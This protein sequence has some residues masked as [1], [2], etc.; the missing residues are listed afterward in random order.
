MRIG[1]K[2]PLAYLQ[3]AGIRKE[4]GS[5]AAALGSH[6]LVVASKRTIAEM[7]EEISGYLAAAG[8][9]CSFHVFA[10][11]I[12]YAEIDNTVASI[13]KNGCDI[14]L[15]LGGGRVLDTARAAADI[16]KIPLIIMPTSASNDAPCSAVAIIHDEN[17]TVIER[18]EVS[19][20]PNLVLVDTEI[21]AK[22]PR[23]LLTS[24]MGDAL[25]TYFE[26]RACNKSSAMTHAGGV[27][28]I[29]ALTLSKLCYDMLLEYGVKALDALDRG[30][31]N[32]DLEQLI[33]AVIYL[34]GAGFENGGTAAS[35]SVN[36][37]FTAIPEGEK[38]LH[39]M[40]VG[41]GVLVQLELENADSD[42]QNEVRAF[43]SKVGLPITLGQ[44]GLP[45][46]SEKDLRTIA[47]YACR[48]P[49]MNNMPFVV[50]PEDVYVAINKVDAISH[51]FLK[52]QG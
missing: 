24:G 13:Q 52:N 17:G 47:E 3:E 19:R 26:S 16:V 39:G 25:A 37:G 4:L 11:D 50:T 14:A 34:S 20:N 32:D 27:S 49:I 36:D 22:A 18:R 21:I 38:L 28:G 45:A 1:V 12:T 40:L 9:E 44:L 51:E 43:M 33:H 8:C 23:K 29:T 7:G 42:V 31:L 41:F 6:A 5:Y 15:G 35:H 46:L 48:A 30:E 2:G 10:G